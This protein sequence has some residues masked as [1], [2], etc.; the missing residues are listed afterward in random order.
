MVES[1]KRSGEY[2]E[3]LRRAYYSDVAERYEDMAEHIL[4]A[5]RLAHDGHIEMDSENRNFFSLAFKNIVGKK[6]N[7]WRMLQSERQK[8]PDDAVVIDGILKKV[9]GEL[10]TYIGRVLDTIEKYF[11]ADEIQETGSK[12]F[13]TKM[14]GD[15][16]RYRA[17]ICEGEA[18]KKAA[19]GALDSY[20]EARKYA[21]TL[22]PTDPVRLGLHLNFSVFY[23]EIMND[24]E[25]ACKLAKEA[26][27]TGISELDRLKEEH[28]K[29]ST[30]MLQLLR[31]NLTLWTTRN[32]VKNDK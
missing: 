2:N 14:K 11:R 32:E 26:F 8:S 9:R 6:R 15:Y 28:Y 7:S 19:S 16:L 29:D 17:E 24:A 31:D 23:Y 21:E 5:I 1:S 27:E 25:E 20:S 3:A 12:V 30:L 18:R 10:E 22:P 4:D 13:V